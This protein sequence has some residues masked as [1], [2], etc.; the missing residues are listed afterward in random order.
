HVIYPEQMPSTLRRMHAESRSDQ[1]DAVGARLGVADA[2]VR[3]AMA[4][5]KTR[6][7]IYFQTDKHWNDRG[8]FVAYR[9]LI[10]AVRAQVPAVPAAWTRDDLVPDERVVDGQDLARMI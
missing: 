6:G 10:E 2:D 3:P 7:R 4:A 8:A 9:E 1:I 5:A